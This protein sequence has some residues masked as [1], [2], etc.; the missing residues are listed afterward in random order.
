VEDLN[1]IVYK[2]IKDSGL[3]LFCKNNLSE[4]AKFLFGVF[5]DTDGTVKIEKKNY[6]T[7]VDIYL[8]IGATSAGKFDGILD[9]EL[10]NN[11]TM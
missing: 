10:K 9:I 2:D 4:N 11:T 7:I 3:S 6:T 1:T 5:I 8:K